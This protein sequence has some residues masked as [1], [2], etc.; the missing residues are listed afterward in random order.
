MFSRA[1][2]FGWRRPPLCW[3]DRA[4]SL[5]CVCGYVS[6]PRAD[7]RL[8][9]SLDNPDTFWSL[10]CVFFRALVLGWWRPP[11]R[12]RD[13]ALSLWCVSFF[14]GGGDL[15]T[16]ALTLTQ[17]RVLTA[18]RV[19]GFWLARQR[20]WVFFSPHCATESGGVGCVA[21]LAD[22]PQ[23]LSLSSCSHEIKK[24]DHQPLLFMSFISL[25]F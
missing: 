24:K 16:R 10:W 12:C 3:R 18:A 22:S 19:R 23:S 21:H 5:W 20:G 17:R 15:R 1:L 25:G 11:S 4:L 9:R 6:S 13:H 2:V 7:G 8:L 14:F